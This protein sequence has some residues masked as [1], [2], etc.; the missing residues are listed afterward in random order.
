MVRS[1]VTVAVADVEASTGWYGR[2]LDCA[3]PL[4]PDHEHRALFDMLCDEAGDPVLFLTRWDHQPLA[5]LRDEAGGRPGH[6]VV[7]FFEVEDVDS[8]WERARALDA[9]VV[10]EPHEGRGFEVT[11]FTVL[12]PDGY[13]VTVSEPVE[14]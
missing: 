2:L 7:L 4:D 12:D 9:D 5:P 11:E 14:V 10:A 3:S 1:T 8:R 13:H 6:G